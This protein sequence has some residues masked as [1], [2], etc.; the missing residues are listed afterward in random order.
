MVANPLGRDSRAAAGEFR[1]WNA[2][3]VIHGGTAKIVQRD[4]S[5]DYSGE[6]RGDFG[7]A[8]VGV[9]NFMPIL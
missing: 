3:S 6:G 7:I 2:G 5:S 9:M 8:R 4:N 1:D